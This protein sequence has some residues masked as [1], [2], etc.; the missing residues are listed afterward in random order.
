[1]KKG[2]K[3]QDEWVLRDDSKDIDKTQTQELNNMLSMLG[4]EFGGTTKVEDELEKDKAQE[5]ALAEF[6]DKK[7]KH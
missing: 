3:R 4:F 1:M 5:T 6:S 7:S 2:G